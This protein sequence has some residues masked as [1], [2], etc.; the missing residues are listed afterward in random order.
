LKLFSAKLRATK[1]DQ[2]ARGFGRSNHWTQIQHQVTK[3]A[4]PNQEMHIEYLADRRE[5]IPTLAQWHYQEWAYL[6]PGDSVE[7]R[8]VRHEG[9]CGR[10][11]IPL[12]FV[13]VSDGELLGSAS[14]V[15]H[16][17]DNRPEL[18][19]WLAGVFVTPERRRQGVGAALVRHIMDEATSVHVSKLYVYTVD[20][21]AFY[22]NLGWSLLEHAA[23]RGKEVSIMSCSTITTKP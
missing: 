6:R 21:T 7:A 14:L 1:L 11:E 9:W 17:M 23:Y 16:E 4:M 12:T 2:C 13:A 22:A 10:G 20:S 18:F 8:I 3:S 19:P 5:F 15:E